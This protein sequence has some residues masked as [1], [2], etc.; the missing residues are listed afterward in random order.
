M[1]FETIIVDA[2]QANLIRLSYTNSLE[3]RRGG[4]HMK[5]VMRRERTMWRK[6][7]SET[8]NQLVN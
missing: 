4:N 1:S 7:K 8:K 6:R 5:M 2:P 3:K